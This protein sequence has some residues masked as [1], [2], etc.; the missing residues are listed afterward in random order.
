[1]TTEIHGTQTR[2]RVPRPPCKADHNEAHG[3]LVRDVLNLCSEYPSGVR[4]WQNQVG[5]G[6]TKR[7]AWV[8]FGLFPGSADVIACVL[9][10]F[11]A[12]ECKTGDG[13]LSREQ[14][15]W[16]DEVRSVGGYAHVVRSRE[17]AKGVIDRIIAEESRAGR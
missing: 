4:A 10:R 5:E 15:D 14:S 8:K 2:R 7:G 16:H 12:L 11:V 13:R 6:K 9:G 3:Q 1:M 17:D